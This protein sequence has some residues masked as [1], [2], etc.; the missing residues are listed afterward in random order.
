MPLVPPRQRVTFL[1]LASRTAFAVETLLSNTTANATTTTTAASISATLSAAL[2]AC[3]TTFDPCPA[4]DGQTMQDDAGISYAVTCDSFIASTDQYA[5]ANGVINTTSQCLQAC[6]ELTGCLGVYF[7]PVTDAVC[8]LITGSIVGVEAQ[9]GYNAYVRQGAP[10]VTTPSSSSY[11]NT[12][13][14]ASRVTTSYYQPTEDPIASPPSSNVSAIAAVP[15]C[16]ATNITCPACDGEFVT[17]ARNRTYKVFCDNQLYADGDY[18]IQR[19]VSPEGCLA[20]CDNY[21]WCMGSTFRPE[22]NCQLAKG[23]NVFPE[24]MKGYT[25]FLPVPNKTAV[26]AAPQSPSAY[27][28]TDGYSAVAVSGPSTFATITSGSVQPS[29]TSSPS[30]DPYIARCPA[31]DGAKVTDWLNQTYTISCNEVPIC[32]LVVNRANHTLQFECL[33]YCDADPVC[34]AA[35][36]ESGSCNLCQ[37]TLEGRTLEVQEGPADYVYYYP[38]SP[39]AVAS[40]TASST[41]SL[42]TNL[43]GASPI[44]P[45]LTTPTMEAI[46]RTLTSLPLVPQP[47]ATSDGTAPAVQAATFVTA[48]APSSLEVV[49]EITL[50]VTELQVAASMTLGALTA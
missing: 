4:C 38:V 21:S 25:A 14:V 6:D 31:C 13:S 37:E 41:T 20:E 3:G 8:T 48:S 47:T 30:C 17:D 11:V 34:F 45:A 2:N 40:R 46:T 12:I 42:A 19:W 35:S 16:P 15:K 29:S 39:G 10:N 28:T 49:I 1:T 26:A 36:W 44:A 33:E 23:Q 7:L 24:E 18:N 5:A 43:G 50:T 9:Q 32:G 27:P 22:G